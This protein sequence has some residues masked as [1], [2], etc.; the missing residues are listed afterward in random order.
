MI[1]LAILL[2]ASAVINLILIFVLVR[3]RDEEIMDI[4]M[5]KGTLM[6]DAEYFELRRMNSYMY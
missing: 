4:S 5:I 3:K 2:F 6:E 1:L